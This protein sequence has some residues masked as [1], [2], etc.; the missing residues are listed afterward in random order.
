MIEA[1]KRPD[2]EVLAFRMV[3]DITKAD[4]EV[5]TP[6]VEKAVEEHGA[7]RLLLDMTEFKW[8]RVE[9]WGSDLRFGRALHDKIERMALVGDQAWGKYLAKIA[10]PF[11][12]HKIEWFH[13]ADKA[14]TWVES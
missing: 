2:T 1:I 7:V 4:Y 11:Y 6:A 14:W 9:A 13:D 5:L 3:G 12:A 10:A 8:E